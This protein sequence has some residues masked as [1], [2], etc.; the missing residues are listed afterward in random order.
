MPE[1]DFQFIPG[2]KVEV[3]FVVVVVFSEIDVTFIQKFDLMRE[4]ILLSF[5]L[6]EESDAAVALLPEPFRPQVESCSLKSSLTT[7]PLLSA[8]I[9][10]P[11]QAVKCFASFNCRCVLVSGS[12]KPSGTSV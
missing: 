4:W 7:S 11:R 12:C 2:A 5:S 8:P 3:V 6:L 1:T 9:N 10:Q